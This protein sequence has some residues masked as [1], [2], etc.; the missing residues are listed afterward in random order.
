MD[1]AMNRDRAGLIDH[2]CGEDERRASN[3]RRRP[4]CAFDAR[5]A[6]CD[7]DVQGQLMHACRAR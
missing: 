4:R 3:D 6:T 5:G 1:D 2:S 7:D